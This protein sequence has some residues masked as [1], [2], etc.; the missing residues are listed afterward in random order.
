M[1][2]NRGTLAPMLALLAV[3]LLIAPVGP[4]PLLAIPFALLL[5]A[6]RPRDLFGVA[7]AAVLIF[8]VFRGVQGEVDGGWYMVRGWCLIA[9]GLFVGLSARG[10]PERLLD[11]SFI[12]VAGATLLM[13]VAAALRPDLGASADGWMA[14]RIREAATMA[15]ALLLADPAVSTGTIGDS[16]GTAIDRWARFQQDVY[17]ALLALATMAALALG[18]YFAGRREDGDRP[19]PVRNFGFRDGYVWLLVAGLALLVLPLG[20]DA[21]RVGENATLF[22]TLMFLARGGA[23]LLWILTA[24]TTSAW[25]WALLGIGMLLA[26]PFVFGAALVV[27][28]GDTWLHLR[29]RLADRAANGPGHR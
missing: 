3:A 26:Y 15:H 19:P 12:A 29:E 4:F 8:L 11:R 16:I 24:A 6:F 22:M 17:P 13:A 23:V 14:E 7:A 5:L 2:R 9:A 20:G 25:T 27:G 1:D 10:R 18:W 28:I 21:F